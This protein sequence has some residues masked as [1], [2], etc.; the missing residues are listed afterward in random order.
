MPSS[1]QDP[2]FGSQVREARSAKGLTQAE[3]AAT[4]G[5]SRPYI[6]QIEKGHRTNVAHDIRA[7][8][9]Q[10]LDLSDE[11]PELPD[12]LPLGLVQFAR[13]DG[14]SVRDATALAGIELRGMKPSTPSDWRAVYQV[15]IG[16]LSSQDH[17]RDTE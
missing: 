5:V 8:I 9:M 15:L 11:V 17:D 3:L 2:S 6:A 13:E 12:Y 4:V 14:L 7:R 10:A 16:L 1:E